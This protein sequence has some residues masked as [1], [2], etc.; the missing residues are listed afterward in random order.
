[1]RTSGDAI[2]SHDAPDAA[3]PA[4]D[5]PP[6]PVAPVMQAEYWLFVWLP[7]MAVGLFAIVVELGA[8]LGFWFFKR[9]LKRKTNRQSLR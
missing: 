2:S 3:P 5:S 4:L 9:K 8:N 7:L 1:M 6:L